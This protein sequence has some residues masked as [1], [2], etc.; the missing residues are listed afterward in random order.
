MERARA[1]ENEVSKSKATCPA[2]F[3]AAPESA[4]E[5]L[6]ASR[7]AGVGVNAAWTG[8]ARRCSGC[9]CVYTIEG[10]RKMLRGYFDNPV[11]TE[12]WL[13]IYS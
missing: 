7:L 11:L 8:E 5:A 2:K 1:G 6:P 10:E 4:Q 13:P 12:G 3:C 9:G